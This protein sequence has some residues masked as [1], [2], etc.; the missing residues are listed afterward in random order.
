MKKIFLASFLLICFSVFAEDNSPFDILEDKFQIKYATLNDGTTNLKVDDIDIG[1]I[2]TTPFINIEIESFMGNGSWEK[3][4]KDK[5]NAII[6]GL[7]DEFRAV[8]GT[9][10]KVSVTLTLDPEIGNKVFLNEGQY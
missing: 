1:M 5:Y 10:K 8:I 4:N 2:N 7:A 6:T 3:F 9:D